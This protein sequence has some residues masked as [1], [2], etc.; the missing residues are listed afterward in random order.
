MTETSQA[1]TALV[2]DDHPVTHL[3]CRGLL[4]EL[5]FTSI[6][7]ADDGGSALRSLDKNAPDLIVLDVG[8]PG[9]GGLALLPQLRKRAP[10]ARILI[11]TMNENPAFAVMALEGGAH[12]FLSKNAPPEE[13]L[14]AV[15]TVLD[16]RIFLE[17]DLAL[18]VATRT[19]R[20]E[21]SLA[22]LTPREL[23]I[24]RL[25]SQ[26]LTYEDIADEVHVSYKTVANVSSALRRKLSA[27]SLPD[28]IRIGLE[29]DISQNS[30]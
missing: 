3:G 9:I 18:S 12:G 29:M 17:P 10:D 21:G 24:L 11:F 4:S 15:R 22:C 1:F 5:G 27:R 20:R 13:F 26:G 2:V 8:L 6:L 16:G 28:L 23:Q 14:Q 30:A 7:K 19:T 25:I